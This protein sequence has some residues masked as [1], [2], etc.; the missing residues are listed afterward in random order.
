MEKLDK[1]QVPDA[2]H[3]KPKKS[4]FAIILLLLSL[5][6]A[7]AY[8]FS[9]SESATRQKFDAFKQDSFLFK[10]ASLVFNETISYEG[11]NIPVTIGVFEEDGEISVLVES[12]NLSKETMMKLMDYMK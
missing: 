1:Y 7:S 2:Y 5:F 3:S 10:E 4:Y 9:S 8:A 12:K 6:I 11:L